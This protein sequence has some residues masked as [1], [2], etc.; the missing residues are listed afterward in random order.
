MKKPV[1]DIKSETDESYQK[2]KEAIDILAQP[3][4][5]V[6]EGFEVEEFRKKDFKDE[7]VLSK[8]ENFLKE[9]KE[10]FNSFRTVLNNFKDSTLK[11]FNN[12]TETNNSFSGF[13]ETKMLEKIK[14]VPEL[15]NKGI[16][17]L[18]EVAKKINEFNKS[19]KGTDQK[20]QS[21]K[22]DFFDKSLTQVLKMTKT[23]DDQIYNSTKSIESNFDDLN[24]KVHQG[25]EELEKNA[26]AYNNYVK[27]LKT[28]GQK[29]ID[30][31][32]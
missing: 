20:A 12:V 26:E 31:W 23:V 15:L 17:L 14:E 22:E 3:L 11:L 13:I 4:S 27:D 28:K 25:K 5:N 2:F 30:T 24:N 8:L 10:T 16:S 1:E 21:E 32:S 19:H 9:L 7:K 29:I 18:P 6:I